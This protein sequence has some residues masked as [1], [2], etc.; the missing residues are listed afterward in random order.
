VAIRWY[1]NVPIFG[2]MM[3]GG[4][5]RNCR[6]RIS[7][8]YPLIELLNAILFVVLYWYEIGFATTAPLSS[9]SLFST[10]GPQNIPGL[11]P[12]SP[13]AF[14]LLR[15]IYHLVLIDALLVASFIDIDLRI[16]PDGA[17]LPAMA[18]GL[19]GGLIGRVH[20][21]PVWFQQ[22]LLF[23]FGPLSVP[24]WITAHPHLHGL[25]VSVAGLLVGGG[26]VW[27]VRIL[28]QWTLKQEAMGF[29]D[30]I[31]MAMI[32]SFLGWQ[33][34]V[35]VFFLAP[36]CALVVVL[37]RLIVRR[38]RMIPYGPYLSLAALFTLL[39]WPALWPQAERILG[40]G[41]GLLLLTAGGTVM[42]G[43]SLVIAHSVKR[44]LG[45][46][47]EPEVPLIWTAADQHHH[48]AG[49][50]VDPHQGNWRPDNAWPGTLTGR[51]LQHTEHWRRNSR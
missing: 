21:V 29:G 12:L 3:L 39:F 23:G 11:G 46:P 47:D 40:M 41:P 44:L 1:D 10:I 15:Y 38:E 25:A 27:T 13:T 45:F 18:V 2:W 24:E 49:E 14:V 5:C 19:L 17:T 26:M 33:P 22:P 6:G 7:P 8:R 9:G 30:V 20:I 51:G 42:L 35:I 37:L 4:R 50:R 31:L 34:T 32:G 48:F 16:I 36:A 28:G 43:I